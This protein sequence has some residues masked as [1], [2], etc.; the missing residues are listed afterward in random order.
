MLPR[1][2]YSL[3]H[4]TNKIIEAKN[5]EMDE[6]KRTLANID[7]ALEDIGR[8]LHEKSEVLKTGMQ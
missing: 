7:S 5:A 3:R 2:L 4:E 6:L 1:T 8:E